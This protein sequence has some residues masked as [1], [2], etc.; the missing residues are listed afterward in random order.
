MNAVHHGLAALEAGIVAYGVIAVFVI[1]YFES[2]GA[3]LPG[4]SALIA[5]SALAAKG[6]VSIAQALLAVW[7]GAVLG[8]STGYL[9]GRLG[10][11]PL[12]QKHGPRVGLTSDRLA[13]MERLFREKG[14]WIVLSARFVVLLRQLNGVIAGSVSMPWPRF[15]VANAIGAALWTAVWGLGPYLLA[16]IVHRQL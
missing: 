7:A 4:E 3:P 12:L 14:A 15:L 10:G 9:I 6:D 16:D 5:I 11:R 2:L 13:T 1:V 8:D